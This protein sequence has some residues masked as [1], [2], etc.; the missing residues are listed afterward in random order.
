MRRR[1][2]GSPLGMGETW[3]LVVNGR[4]NSG[5]LQSSV[6]RVGSHPDLIERETGYVFRTGD[7]DGL[8]NRLRKVVEM[9]P[10]RRRQVT[11]R[12]RSSL[13]LYSAGRG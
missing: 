1:T 7:A 4:S 5:C 2:A 13:T 11:E 10:D 8:R 6:N 12:C 3:G 9:T